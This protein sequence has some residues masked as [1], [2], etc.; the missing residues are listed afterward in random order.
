MESGGIL[1]GP[2][3]EQQLPGLRREDGRR[4]VAEL[5]IHP[6]EALEGRLAQSAVLGLH[7]GDIGAV[8][9]RILLTLAVLRLREGQVRIVEHGVDVVRRLGHLSR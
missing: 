3:K 5:P 6:I 2:R 9:D 4:G 8:G 1:P 7:Q